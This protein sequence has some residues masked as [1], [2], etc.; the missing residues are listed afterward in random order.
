MK[1]GG[2]VRAE[3][4]GETGEKFIKIR[5]QNESEGRKMTDHVYLKICQLHTRK[6]LL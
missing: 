6:I 3:L 1:L 4:F 5:T 2:K